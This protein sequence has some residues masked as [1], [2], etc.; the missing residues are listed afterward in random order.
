LPAE[1]KMMPPD[2]Q[3]ITS[4]RIPT[5]SFGAGSARVIA[6]SFQG[7]EGP[8]RSQIPICL[9]D[10]RLDPGAQWMATP[11][12]GNDLFMC[13][14]E[15]AIDASESNG[16]QHIV[17]APSVAVFAGKGDVKV[18]AGVEGAEI[19][20]CEGEPIRETVEKYGPF[21]MN[22]R[23]ELQQAVDDFNSGN[24]AGN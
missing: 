23:Q 5:V 10:V 21:V 18:T 20:Y 8:A 13:I 3:D 12:V 15:G 24:L 11:A 6:G 7:V 2:Y 14:Y 17:S 1:K 4:D 16:S 9:M 22:T 19:L